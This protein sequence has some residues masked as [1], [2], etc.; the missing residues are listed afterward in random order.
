MLNF[1]AFAAIEHKLLL[2]PGTI[3]KASIAVLSTQDITNPL[4]IFEASVLDN[5]ESSNAEQMRLL[6]GTP[7]TRSFQSHTI[8]VVCERFVWK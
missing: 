3:Y 2:I 6:Y 8:L 5:G 7:S 1:H 4:T